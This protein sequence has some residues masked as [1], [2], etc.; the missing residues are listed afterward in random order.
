MERLPSAWAEQS[1][2]WV[3]GEPHEPAGLNPEQAWAWALDNFEALCHRSCQSC[4]EVHSHGGQPLHWADARDGAIALVARGQ[5][6]CRDPQAQ[7]P[8]AHTTEELQS[9]AGGADATM[10]EAQATLRQPGGA[11]VGAG[12]RIQA[13]SI[14]RSPACPSKRRKTQADSR[15]RAEEEGIPSLGAGSQLDTLPQRS[16]EEAGQL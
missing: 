10:S 11:G 1:L 2:G 7:E 15:Q 14:C 8:M 12:G 16:W 3:H 9:P 5:K 6:R 13:Q 4:G